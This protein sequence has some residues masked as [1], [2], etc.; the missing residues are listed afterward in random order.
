MQLP[1]YAGYPNGMQG[2]QRPHM[3]MPQGTLAQG[4]MGMP[5]GPMSPVMSGVGN[6][7]PPQVLTNPISTYSEMP[8]APFTLYAASAVAECCTMACIPSHC[9]FQTNLRGANGAIDI[10]GGAHMP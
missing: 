5:Q 3:G 7:Q 2:Q 6:M 10:H 4:N 8:A 1:G 9:L